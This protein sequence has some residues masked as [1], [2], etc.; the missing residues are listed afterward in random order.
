MPSTITLIMAGAIFGFGFWGSLGKRET[1]LEVKR[2]AILETRKEKLFTDLVKIERQHRSGKIGLTKHTSR[3]TE[4]IS[5]LE[6]VYRELDE[7]LTAMLISSGRTRE[8]HSV[9]SPGTAG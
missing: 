8:S 2:R 4:L 5:A 9:E 6:R 7:Q 3:R 1:A